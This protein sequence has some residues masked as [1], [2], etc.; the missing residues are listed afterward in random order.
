MMVQ[1]HRIMA[2]TGETRNFVRHLC[3]Q[4]VGNCICDSPGN[5]FSEFAGIVLFT[6]SLDEFK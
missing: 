1:R 6:L 4:E 2:L 5:N 3:K